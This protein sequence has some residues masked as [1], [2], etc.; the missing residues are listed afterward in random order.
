MRHTV[1]IYYDVSVLIA[2]ISCTVDYRELFALL[3][4]ADIIQVDAVNV[5]ATCN[6][7]GYPAQVI[8]CSWISRVKEYE[9][10]KGKL[11]GLRVYAKAL[12]RYV[13]L[14]IWYPMDGRTDKWQLYYL[15]SYG[16]L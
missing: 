16:F 12:K 1:F 8:G 7:L 4:I 15:L 9:V 10:N 2:K 5:I 6:F 14:A 11:Y 3:R 13:S